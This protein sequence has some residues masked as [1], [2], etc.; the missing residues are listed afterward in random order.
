MAPCVPHGF[1]S[2]SYLSQHISHVPSNTEATVLS[3]TQR[4]YLFDTESQVGWGGLII[5]IPGVCQQF[6]SR[7]YL[8]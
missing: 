8:E 5:G 2:P 7:G 3:N 1:L 6:R 4:T